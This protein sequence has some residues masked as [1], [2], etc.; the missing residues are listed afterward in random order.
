MDTRSALI[1]WNPRETD[2]A[3]LEKHLLRGDGGSLIHPTVM[4]RRSA[5]EQVGRYRVEAQW[6]EDL[7]LFLRLAQV[8]Q[9]ANL[10]D[11]LLNY[12]YHTESVNFTRNEG[13][14]QRKLW[15]MEQAHA[16]RGLAFDRTQW[17]AQPI[18]PSIGADDARE[19]AL[20]SLR[21]PKRS[22]PWRYAFRAARLAPTDPRSWQVLNY[23]LK[24]ML[25]FAPRIR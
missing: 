25:G 21:F 2:H 4:L 3:L 6:V 20:T 13:R 11:V 15:V 1:K 23:V 16:A 7:D 18:N 10:P 22:T 24:A 8:G 17:P 19:F 5:V 14:H 12:R 9:L